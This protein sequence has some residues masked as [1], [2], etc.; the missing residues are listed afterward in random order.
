MRK[1]TE[2]FNHLLLLLVVFGGFLV[3]GFSENIKGPAIPR[4]QADFGLDEGQ[5][6]VL[7]ALNSLGYL[8]ACTFTSALSRR[9][10]IKWTGIAA[11]A[12]M[13]IAGVL[14]HA[15]SGYAF[16]S[17]SYLLMYIGNGMLEIGL[18]IMAARIFT[19]NT[20]TMMNMAHFFYGLSSI[21]APIIASAMIGWHAPGGG[22][23]GWR[24]MYMIMLSLSVLPILPS[25][26]GKFPE[27]APHEAEERISYRALV[28]DPVAWLIVALLSFGVISE[29]AVG[30]WLV[31]FLEK[32]YGWSMGSAS[33]MLSVFFLFFTLARLFLG[34]VTDRI[35]YTLSVMI[36]AA[37]SG[38][39]S[40]AAIAIGEGGAILFAIAG[41]GIAPI[42]PTVMAMIAKRYPRGTDTAIT[43]TVT[44]MGVASV[45]GN[46]FI[47][48]I[49]DVVRAL[50]E[51]SDGSDRSR[52]LGL[53][54]GYAF[55]ALM[56][57]LS[58]V[59]CAV[60]YVMLR[61]RGEVI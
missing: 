7:L 37:F 8:A 29:L 17:A 40:L 30:N 57:L 24:G 42:Y 35:G 1:H 39:C 12:S 33:G 9:V 16:L 56:A 34:P 41:A 49:I 54:A 59:C 6:G 28:R 50:F 26:W 53:E 5:L 22:T 44:L 15:A 10:G 19:R 4:I 18:A 2:R 3:F 47:G 36:F 27:E 51:G 52:I 46:L 25:L 11:F 14:M 48:Y 38:L 43:F 45:L 20:G 21:V 31:N 55:I 23:L 32:A 13:A 58:A 60:L 61:K